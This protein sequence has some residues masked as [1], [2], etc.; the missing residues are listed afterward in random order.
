MKQLRPTM[1]TSEL[2]V[3]DMSYQSKKKVEKNIV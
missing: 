1:Y 3:T 2:S